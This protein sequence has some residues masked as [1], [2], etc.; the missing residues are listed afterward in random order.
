VSTIL[1][2]NLADRLR[3]VCTYVLYV[4]PHRP[5]SEIHRQV[6]MWSAGRQTGLAAE[7]SAGENVDFLD[8]FRPA[9]V[10]KYRP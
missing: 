7:R 6:G 4:R 5:A 9:V 2:A 3:C 10:E 8:K 1:E